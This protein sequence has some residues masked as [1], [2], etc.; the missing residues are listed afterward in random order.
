L[1]TTFFTWKV[2]EKED[3]T[4]RRAWDHDILDRWVGRIGGVFSQQSSDNGS[5]WSEPVPITGGGRAVRGNLVE[6]EDGT[7]I[8]PTYGGI[9]NKGQIFIMA[10]AD[11]GKTWERLAKL[12]IEDYLFHDFRKGH[13]RLQ[14]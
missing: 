3:V 12:E 4:E 14:S 5:T 11:R 10:S 13:S 6:I 9:E 2:L 7:L 8:L 1:F